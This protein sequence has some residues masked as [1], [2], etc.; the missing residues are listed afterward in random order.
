M[1]NTFVENNYKFHALKELIEVKK[2]GLI[3]PNCAFIVDNYPDFNSIVIRLENANHY[4][5]TI[6]I[7][8]KDLIGQP[9]AIH[10]AAKMIYS[11][12]KKGAVN[13]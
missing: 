3:C 10:K 4:V 12:Y 9:K 13:E 11:W 2:A 1:V 5:F 8:Y 7:N 6:A